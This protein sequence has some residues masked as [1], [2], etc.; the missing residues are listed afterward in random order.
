MTI[1]SAVC[2]NQYTG[3]GATATYAFSFRILAEADLLVTS[4]TTAGVEST[5]VLD[6]DY[7]VSWEE[8]DADGTITLT[9]GNLT[10]GYGLTIR[11]ERDMTQTTDIRNGGPFFQELVENAL[12]HQTMLS[13]QLQAQVDRSLKVAETDDTDL[14][15]TLPVAADRASNYLAFDA[16]G[17]PI[18][19]S[20]GISASVPVSAFMETVLDDTTAS[21]ALT[22][23]GVSTFAKTVLDDTTAA[24]ALTTLGVATYPQ[25]VLAQTYGAQSTGSPDQRYNFSIAC[26]VGAGA[27]TINLV[28]KAGTTASA[29]DPVLI[30]Y[31]NATPATGTFSVVATTGAVSLV[32]NSTA[33]LGLASGSL[34]EYVYVYGLNNA[35]ATELFVV[36]GAPVIDDGSIVSTTAISTA[37]DVR[38]TAYST[39]ARSNVPC[40]LLARLK[41]SLTTAGTWDEVPDEISLFPFRNVYAARHSVDSDTG[42]GHGS[43]DTKIRRITNSTTVGTAITVAN[44]AGNGNTYT[45]NEEGMYFMS[46][47]DSDSTG[48]RAMG[49]SLNSAELTTSVASIVVATKLALTMG[50]GA[51]AVGFCSALKRLSPGDIVRPHTVGTMDGTTHCHFHISKVGP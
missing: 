25:A 2:V 29:T 13:Q 1:S 45:I 50:I 43:T 30:G 51:N 20:G 9:A 49:I 27:L 28:S 19:S 33:T 14:D 42:N 22:T 48:G 5:L 46:Y 47:D 18:A 44:S 11:R 7:T 40:K 21:A 34:T 37:A 32:V 24:A 10:S 12:D 31:R 3:N 41:F 17:E 35:G 38:Y 6:T 39:T 16:D 8:G 4:V 36:G 23:L 26:S 15:M